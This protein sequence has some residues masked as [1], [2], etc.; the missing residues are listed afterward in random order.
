MAA[1]RPL[2]RVRVWNRTGARAHALAGWAATEAGLGVPVEVV[3]TPG[4]AT[5]GA[6]LVC[7]V[8]AS[9]EPLV[10]LADVAPGVHV[11]AVGAYRPDTRELAGDLVGAAARIVV[12]DAAAAGAESGDLL[13]AVQEGALAAD[14]GSDELG[15]LLAA[16]ERPPRADDDITVFVSLGLAVQDVAA[17]SSAL[18]RARQLGLG[19][20]VAL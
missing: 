19:T 12:D 14:H 1:V 9:P 10:G 6:D 11:N 7:T 13:L 8:T 4:A 15:A 5:T 3:D 2:R 18:A 17:A 16:G 20:D